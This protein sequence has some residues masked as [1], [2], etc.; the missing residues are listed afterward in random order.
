MDGSK[1]GDFEGFFV[2][3]CVVGLLVGLPVGVFVL[4][5]PRFIQISLS[6]HGKLHWS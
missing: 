2:G 1:V 3:F 5:L 6:S 4:A